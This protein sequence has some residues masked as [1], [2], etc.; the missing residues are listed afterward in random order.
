MAPLI[1]YIL[2]LFSNSRTRNIPYIVLFV[3]LCVFT[4]CQSISFSYHSAILPLPHDLRMEDFIITRCE[5]MRMKSTY[6]LRFHRSGEVFRLESSVVLGHS[7]VKDASRGH[8]AESDCIA[9]GLMSGRWEL[10]PNGDRIK[11]FLNDITNGVTESYSAEVQY[12]N[13]LF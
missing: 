9:G 7:S 3:G 8:S 1:P 10:S 13:L 12:I 4:V 5:F 11:F 2:N 6:I